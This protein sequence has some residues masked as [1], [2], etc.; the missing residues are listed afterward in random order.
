MITVESFIYQYEGKQQ[1]VMLYL[2][3][4]LI[5]EFNLIDKIRY[6]IP[7][8]DYKSW[9]CYQNPKRNGVV[10]LAFTK[11]NK[12]SNQQGLLESKGRKQVSS[13]EFT[14]LAEIPK[15][16]LKEIIH[17]AI[18]LDEYEKIK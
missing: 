5:K 2:H 10:E 16:Q 8:Y 9:I 4:L 11:G 14:S 17:E 12:L 18:L 13:I 7:F 15:Q 1:E 3:H 6:K